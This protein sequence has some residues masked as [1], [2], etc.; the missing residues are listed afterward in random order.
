VDNIIDV[1][2]DSEKL[3]YNILDRELKL[4]EF[5]KQANFEP[6]DAAREKKN[7]F[8]WELRDRFP[9]DTPEDVIMSHAYLS[10]TA[11]HIPHTDLPFIQQRINEMADFMGLDLAIPNKEASKEVVFD[12]PLEDFAVRIPETGLPEDM[13]SKYANYLYNGH[14]VLYPLGTEKQIKEA[15]RNFPA[16][17]DEDLEYFRPFIAKDIANKLDHENLAPAVK[18]YLPIPK[19]AAIEQLALRAAN[20]P[21]HSYQYEQLAQLVREDK[22]DRNLFP[23]ALGLADRE[24]GAEFMCKSANI[25][26]AH[27]YIMGIVDDMPRKTHLDIGGRKIAFNTFS[28]MANHLADMYPS[29]KYN[30][31]SVHDAQN[32]VDNLSSLETQYILDNIHTLR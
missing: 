11:K 21:D 6:G 2:D 14:L 27:R 31:D 17:L 5:V 25:Y 7:I 9:L 12:I 13:R 24:S 8:A 16:G 1:Y 26:E 29:I 15:N 22:A 4:P 30:M 18:E 32:F 20:Y 23:K 28:K 19:S 10:K 3:I